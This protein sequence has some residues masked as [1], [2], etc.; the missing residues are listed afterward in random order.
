MDSDSRTYKNSR[1]RSVNKKVSFSIMGGGI[2]FDE[3]AEMRKL[4]EKELD[5]FIENKKKQIN[6]YLL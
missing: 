3:I 5:N 4:K 2:T 6:L 1:R